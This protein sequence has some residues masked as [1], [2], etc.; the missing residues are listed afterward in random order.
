MVV[1]LEVAPASYSW[2]ENAVVIRVR[3]VGFRAKPDTEARLGPNHQTKW[4]ADVGLADGKW[5]L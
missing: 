2:M 3:E 4:Q 5:E 1:R